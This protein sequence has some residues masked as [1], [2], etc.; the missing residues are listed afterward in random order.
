MASQRRIV[1]SA[2]A[3]A[4]VLPSGEYLTEA[5]ARRWPSHTWA[6]VYC[7]TLSVSSSD[8]DVVDDDEG[9]EE[10]EEEEEGDGRSF[11]TVSG[12]SPAILARFVGGKDMAV[13]Q[14]R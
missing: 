14:R 10:E 6:I 9:E 11:W 4:R 3:L 8:D 12:S 7:G 5:T 1:V 13:I 2:E